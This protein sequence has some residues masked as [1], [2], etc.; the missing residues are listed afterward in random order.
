MCK[1]TF[2]YRKAATVIRNSLRLYT[3]MMQYRRKNV[4]RLDLSL[5]CVQVVRKS[6]R[7]MA[8]KV[9]Y[10]IRG[11]LQGMRVQKK[12]LGRNSTTIFM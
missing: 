4:Q 10:G 12:M 2:K 9:D 7:K 8:E 11:A 3:N 5:E 1:F 6:K